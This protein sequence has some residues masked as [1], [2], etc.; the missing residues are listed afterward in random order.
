MNKSLYWRLGLITAVVVIAIVIFVPSLPGVRASLPKWWPGNKVNLGLDLQGG[1]HLVY[2]VQTEKAVESL[3]G[4]L[5]TNLKNT[6]AEKNVPLADI[7]QVTGRELEATLSNPSDM[8]KFLGLVSDLGV[9]EKKSQEGA[10]VV[11][12]VKDKEAERIKANSV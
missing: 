2:Q 6:A 5:V 12:A 11:L 1:M 3:T 9:L 8:D 7:K 10:K 4:R